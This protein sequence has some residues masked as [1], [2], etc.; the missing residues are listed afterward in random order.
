[1]STIE[2]T[3]P[4][5]EDNASMTSSQKR[6]LTPEQKAKMQAG[7]AAHK[8]KIAAMSAE[9]KAAYK[10]QKVAE[11]EAKAARKA[12]KEA[13]KAD[14]AEKEVAK[15][16]KAKRVLTPEQK[17]KMAAG[18]A[19][20]R[21]KIAAMSPEE[22]EAL[23]ASKAAEKSSKEKKV[24]T[25]K[26]IETNNE[27]KTPEMKPKQE[28]VCPNAPR[29]FLEIEG[30]NRYWF[31][32]SVEMLGAED[33]DFAISN[34]AKFID[35]KPE[36][37]KE[38]LIAR[39]FKGFM[40][41]SRKMTQFKLKHIEGDMWRGTFETLDKMYDD[42]IHAELQDLTDPDKH[43]DYPLNFDGFT[44]NLRGELKDYAKIV[45]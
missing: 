45:E 18:A 28:L 22:K 2:P 33:D 1:M 29:K 4:T 3:T 15:E 5:I 17:A 35:A 16:N 30:E 14:K 41:T 11:K 31:D 36:E 19:A 42:D 32:F 38:K 21:A 43:G 24:E 34:E 8:A 20:Y 12:A 37:T 10:A 23:K 7:L 39:W 27:P 9:E 40:L 25:P 13:A 44:Y 6:S 26:Q